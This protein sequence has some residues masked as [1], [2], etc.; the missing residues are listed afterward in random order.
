MSRY[1][2][3]AA[4][5][6]HG[7]FDLSHDKYSERNHLLV[8]AALDPPWVSSKKA[9]RARK[10]YAYRLTENIIGA[11]LPCVQCAR[12]TRRIATLEAVGVAIGDFM[13]GNND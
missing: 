5:W 13:A 7:P 1:S 12:E 3:S 6:Q 9:G 8:W 4:R 2:S 11:K 10:K